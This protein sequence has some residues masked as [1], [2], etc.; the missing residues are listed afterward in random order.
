MQYTNNFQRDMICDEDG[1]Y[2]LTSMSDKE[3]ADYFETHYNN[4][5]FDRPLYFA[6]GFVSCAAIVT[7]LR[8]F[9]LI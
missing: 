1:G 2:T 7:L 9:K 6:I 8:I 5:W 3:R 4:H